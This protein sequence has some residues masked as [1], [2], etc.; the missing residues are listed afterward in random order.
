VE[1]GARRAGVSESVVATMP[2]GVDVRPGGRV[3]WTA[4]EGDDHDVD[5]FP[6]VVSAI[7]PVMALVLVGCSGVRFQAGLANA[8]GINRS[9]TSEDFGHDVIANGDETCPASGRAEDDPLFHRWPPCGGTSGAIQ[10]ARPQ[11]AGEGTKPGPLR[12][13]DVLSPDFGRP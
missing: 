13:P 10:L 12:E 11:R 1:A 4:V 3:D 9:W 6:R 8:P 5:A 2:P 7:A